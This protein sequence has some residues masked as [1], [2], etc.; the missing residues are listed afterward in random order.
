[1]AQLRCLAS[2]T[3]KHPR[4]PEFNYFHDYSFRINDTDTEEQAKKLREG[5]VDSTYMETARKDYLSTGSYNQ[6]WH[7]NAT[8]VEDQLSDPKRTYSMRD[9]LIVKALQEEDDIELVTL[10]CVYKMDT[11]TTVEKKVQDWEKM[12]ECIFVDGKRTE[13]SGQP[14]EVSCSI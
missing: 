4:P 14:A 8:W 11:M 3:L 12:I 9:T 1:M 6:E 2:I 13:D 10:E 7:L 5:E